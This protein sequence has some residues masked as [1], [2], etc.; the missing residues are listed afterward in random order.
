MNSSSVKGRAHWALRFLPVLSTLIF[1]VVWCLAAR[2]TD[3]L[4]SFFETLGALFEMLFRPSTKVTLLQHVWA[5]LCRVL[6]AYGL[7]IATGVLLGVAFGRSR[8][9]HDYCFP[10]FELLRPIPPIAWIPLVI[11]WL[12]I[13]ESSKIAVC[14]IGAV[15]PILLNTYFGVSALDSTFLKSAKVL[16]AGRWSTLV[17]V[18]LPGA[19]PSILTGMKV[20]LSSGWVCVIAAEMIAA[21]EGLGYLIIRSMESGDMVHILVAMIFIGSIN[22]L[23]SWL[24]SKLERVVCPW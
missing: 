7:A 21:K 23:F 8:R 4:P 20:A 22:F 10:I 12:G 2:Y 19:L 11:M 13:G 14:F 6:A 5:S 3:L 24:F 18:V 16:G 17:E 15:V 9:F 1:L